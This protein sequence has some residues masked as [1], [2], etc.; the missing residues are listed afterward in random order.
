MRMIFHFNYRKSS[1]AKTTFTIKVFT[2]GLKLT[3]TIGQNSIDFQDS[4]YL[5]RFPSLA[6]FT[7]SSNE[8]DITAYPTEGI[9]NEVL[10]HLHLNIVSPLALSLSVQTDF[11]R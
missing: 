7:L 5:I 4:S 1:N 10:E 2:L 6:D 8:Q 9:T 11:A 3:K